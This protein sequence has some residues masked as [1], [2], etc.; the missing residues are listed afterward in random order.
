MRQNVSEA[1]PI[2][3]QGRFLLERASPAVR[4]LLVKERVRAMEGRLAE[5]LQALEQATS[6]IKDR[7]RDLVAL[8]LLRAELLR[9]DF[10]EDESLVVMQD[11]VEPYLTALTAEERLGI[12][13]NLSELRWY[14][15]E[16]TGLFYN[17][18]D[19]RRALNFDWLDYRELFEAKLE[20]DRGKHFEAL[21]ILWQQHRHAYL[22]G[23]WMVQRW[24]NYLLAKECVHLKEWED[25]VH[26][27]IFA[28][29]DN[30][31]SEIST[32]VLSSRRADLVG[33]IVNRLLTAANLRTH[34]IAACKLL[35]GLA[36]AIP[37]SMISNVGEW[38]LKRARE[39]R[40]PV[41]GESHVA[42]AWETIYTVAARFSRDLARVT[43]ATAT[44]H[45][46]WTTKLDDPKRVIPERRE[47]VRA[48][49]PLVSA[50][51]PFEM[52]PLAT[53]TVPLLTDR[54]QI[55][56]YD[57]VVNLLCFIATRGG[58]EVRESLAIVL[59]PA[60]KPISRTLAQVAE[61]FGKGSIFDEARVQAIAEQ[62]T[63]EIRRQVQWLAPDQLPEPV[64]EQII[65]YNSSKKDQTLKVYLVELSGL[66]AVARQRAKLGESAL[67]SLVDAILHQSRNRDNFCVN[68]Q[69]LL[70]ALMEFMDILPA[71]ERDK[72]EAAIAPL[73][74]GEVEE[75]AEYPTAEEIGNP[76]NPFKPRSGR[77]E[78]VQGMALVALAA[79]AAGNPPAIKRMESALENALC[80]HRPGIRRA[81][82]AAALRLP[83]VS[84]GI[85]LG[86]LAGLRDPDPNAA[87]AAFMT[88]AE[89]NGWRLNRNHW[90]VF[91]MAVRFAQRTG[92]ANLRRHAAAAIIAWS[93]KCPHRLRA[94]Q[95]RLITEFGDDMCWSVRANAKRSREGD[96]EE[97]P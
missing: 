19:R 61:S 74:R 55:T 95:S 8:G 71:A 63:E 21:P 27:A 13:Q 53:A 46:Y 59:Y 58:R 22:Q 81:G 7:P 91:L 60:G 43:V 72:A 11:A 89:Q 82:Y 80:D 18:V 83:H 97:S 57:K 44:A 85:I 86:V 39:T 6:L 69:S 73:A 45:P 3:I 34:F 40:M 15:R 12:E 33:R 79:L 38:L 37:D 90:R 35:K 64:A 9:L 54:Q 26:H 5:A 56:D 41:S 10:M 16:S 50:L 25:A 87:A 42:A 4:K 1:M 24:T 67:R 36:D 51:D 88:L 65:E 96:S 49:M 68:R 23:C 28:R 94:E 29:D 52:Q 62:V 75:S 32:G 76:L 20:A 92:P 48:L 66:Y 84:E 14:T 78:D 93:S 2:P 70:R 77:P 30:L 17:I 47:I 31:L